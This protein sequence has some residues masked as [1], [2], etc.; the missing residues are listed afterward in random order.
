MPSAARAK[1][2]KGDCPFGPLSIKHCLAARL[3]GIRPKYLT[4]IEL[5]RFHQQNT[6][7][8]PLAD[9]IEIAARV[10]LSLTQGTHHP[11]TDHPEQDP[12]VGLYQPKPG[13][14][15]VSGASGSDRSGFQRAVWQ[16]GKF[17]SA[18][19]GKA[20]IASHG[21]AVQAIDAAA[22]VPYERA[23]DPVTRSRV[24][25]HEVKD[26]TILHFPGKGSVTARDAKML[27]W[28][29]PATRPFAETLGSQA[30]QSAAA[31][32][33][34][35]QIQQQQPQEEEHPDLKAEALPDPGVEQ[36]LTNIVINT[37][38]MEQHTAIQELVNSGDVGERTL[39]TLATQLN[40]EPTALKEQFAPV[41]ASFEKQARAVMSEGGVNSD[42]VVAY[43]QQ[44][45]PDM[46]RR[47]MHKQ[48]TMR[49]T[50]GYAE[51]RQSFI[52]NLAKH[53]PSAALN[54][55]LGPGITQRQDQKGRVI[56]RFPD[57]SEVE[58]INAIRAFGRR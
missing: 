2:Y 31:A 44:H 9:I 35:L 17:V 15:D 29:A 7:L 16:D 30:T 8:Y 49:N 22:G 45:Q 32:Q 56:V 36:V 21:A 3:L 1:R 47:A 55:D 11:M 19:G 4:Q 33:N 27:G 24:A 5:R 34:D 40:I 13:N 43:G 20:T 46:L 50:S 48:A 41:M 53:N 57:G 28:L 25:P 42:D 37:G 54:A 26:D 23:E 39:N 18:E 10:S 12:R 51:L 52:E 6:Y 58:W 38:G 14:T